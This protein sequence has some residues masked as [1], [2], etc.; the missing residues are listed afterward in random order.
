MF[1]L[2]V[3]TQP[4]CENL[5]NSHSNHP[6]SPSASFSCS[7]PSLLTKPQD[8]LVLGSNS[9]AW[10]R[11]ISPSIISWAIFHTPANNWT[12]S[13]VGQVIKTTRKQAWW[14]YPLQG[15]NLTQVISIAL[16]CG[17]RPR[18]TLEFLIF[19]LATLKMNDFWSLFP[20]I[21]FF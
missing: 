21:W 2:S 14:L 9:W 17:V 15:M 18:N 12:Q 19:S 4:L 5:R 10:E 7:L 13:L 1:P 20:P 11:S 3:G 8:A 6:W 16:D